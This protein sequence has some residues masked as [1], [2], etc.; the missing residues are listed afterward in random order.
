[1]RKRRRKNAKA[2]DPRAPFV[3][4]AALAVMPLTARNIVQPGIEDFE[5]VALLVAQR[6]RQS[7]ELLSS[8]PAPAAV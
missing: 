6:L 4:M 1:M 3:V 5:A 7:L 8:G 2:L